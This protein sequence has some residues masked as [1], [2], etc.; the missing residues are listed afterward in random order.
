MIRHKKFINFNILYI[1]F[2]YLITQGHTFSF[3]SSC[4]LKATSRI[5]GG[6]L[7]QPEEFPWQISLQYRNS[8]IC[9]GTLI[10]ERLVVT[11]AHCVDGQNFAY[12]QIVVGIHNLREQSSLRRTVKVTKI[13]LVPGYIIGKK[14]IKYDIALLKLGCA[15]PFVNGIPKKGQLVPA[16]FPE[17][18]R[19]FAGSSCWASGWGAGRFQ[20]S[21]QPQL[22]KLRLKLLS[23]CPK[24]GDDADKI[25]TFGN[26]KTGTCQGDSG[27]P[28]SCP[29]GSKYYV[30]GAVSFGTHNSCR[31]YGYF[32][33]VGY[34]RKW[35]IKTAQGWGL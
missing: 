25:C 27:G 24:T 9:G 12:F 21:L 10:H 4:G 34:Y 14:R 6:T 15:V 29:V 33:S 17:T 19:N 35:I 16:C 22:H 3:P 30:A 28:I 2:T 13:A 18:G 23:R 1:F 20:G 11:A 5:V 31:S 7:A 8:H 26:W 32:T